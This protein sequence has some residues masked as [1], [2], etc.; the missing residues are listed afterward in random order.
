[1]TRNV[2]ILAF[3]FCSLTHLQK[4]QSCGAQTGWDGN[5]QEK[6]HDSAVEK[7]GR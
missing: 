1:M 3:Q 6:W 5:F 7:E 2:N 4:E